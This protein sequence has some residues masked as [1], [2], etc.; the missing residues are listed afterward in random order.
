MMEVNA[1]PERLDLDS[2][3]VKRAVE[4]GVILTINCDAHHPDDF[5]SLSFGLATAQRGWANA[6]HIGNTYALEQLLALKK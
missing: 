4:L 1:S 5:A 2:I 6:K 3:Y